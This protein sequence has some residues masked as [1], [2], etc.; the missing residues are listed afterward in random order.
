MRKGWLPFQRLPDGPVR[1]SEKG[2]LEF[3]RRRG[4][5]IEQVMAKTV[6][7]EG[8]YEPDAPGI[9]SPSVPALTG[10]TADVP[11]EAAAD[12]DSGPP[13]PDSSMAGPPLA[14]EAPA[15]PAPVA[16]WP[17]PDEPADTADPSATPVADETDAPAQPAEPETPVPDS[18]AEPPAAEPEPESEPQSQPDADA[19]PADEPDDSQPGEP[20]EQFAAETPAD[21]APEPVGEAP[22][23]E[24][25][26][27]EQ[28]EVNRPDEDVG[29]AEMAPDAALQIADAIVADAVRRRASDIHLEPEGDRLSLRMRID[30][31]LQEKVNFRRLLPGPL[32]DRLIE[33]FKRLAGLDPNQALPQSGRFSQHVEGR[34]VELRLATLPTTRGEKIVIGIDP[35]RVDQ[36]DLAALGFGR[37][38]ERLLRRMLS[39]PAGLILMAAPPRNGRAETLRA[40]A[41]ALN[42]RHRSIA[43]IHGRSAWEID[44]A[45][46]IVVGQVAGLS[47]PVAIGAAAAADSDV[48]L[49]DELRGPHEAS[50]AFE[51]AAAGRIV[52]AGIDAP[53]GTG[54][55]AML[56]EA[57]LGGW[58]LAAALTG[59][60][61]RR[62]VRQLCDQCKQQVD[63]SAELISHAGFSV[64][65]I[66]SGVYKARGCPQCANS[67]YAGTVGLFSVVCADGEV[68]RAI[69]TG[70]CAIAI[71]EAAAEDGMKSLRPAALEKV[72]A[73]VTSL[74]EVAR[75]LPG[76]V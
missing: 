66:G 29:E 18:P 49:I 2:L 72:R 23:V 59:A 63:P 41:G 60:V 39:E 4:I 57:G 73:G 14:A 67:G 24:P 50:A 32:A 61:A 35:A 37:A 10:K 1:I 27:P 25:D 17:P 56:V 53:G 19:S 42:S 43:A 45:G 7:E 64:E 68:A 71:E 33:R 46:E 21:P 76:W 6:L 70:G 15:L 13:E 11:A 54:A 28:P 22:R 55:I 3:L 58:P 34:Q 8:K 9:A 26:P 69:R 12:R 44:G 31:V 38:G 48:I 51:A 20:V 74:E 75:V 52:L 40:M 62:T 30:G 65:Q 36:P 47:A 5:D 16:P